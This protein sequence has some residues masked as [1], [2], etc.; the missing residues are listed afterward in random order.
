MKYHCSRSSSYI[1]MVNMF[2]FISFMHDKQTHKTHQ[3][4]YMPLIFDTGHIKCE[5]S[6]EYLLVIICKKCIHCPE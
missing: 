6:I 1:I 5:I 2:K 4:Q 3:K